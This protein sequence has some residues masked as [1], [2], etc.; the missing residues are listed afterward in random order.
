MSVTSCAAVCKELATRDAEVLGSTRAGWLKPTQVPSANLLALAVTALKQAIEARDAYTMG[1]SRRV[2]VLAVAMAREMGLRESVVR[3]LAL[4]AELHDVGKIGIPDELL[5]KPGALTR[6]EHQRILEH[7]VIGER[8]LRPLMAGREEI[9]QAVRAHH[10]RVDG[11]GYPDGLKG[12][13]IPLTARILAVADAFDAMTSA[14]PY[15]DPLKP[16]VAKAELSRCTGSHFDAEC[17]RALLRV[18]SLTGRGYR[19]SSHRTAGGERKARVGAFSFPTS[20][21]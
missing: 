18:D 12:D 10:E 11:T 2:R 21:M 19:P 15:R 5:H 4:A 16:A 13:Q 3:D 7:T 8:I 1:H 17:V 9:L 6:E 14:R 20:V